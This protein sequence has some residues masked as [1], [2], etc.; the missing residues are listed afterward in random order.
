M[1]YL[2]KMKGHMDMTK[3]PRDLPPIALQVCVVQDVTS[4]RQLVDEIQKYL[5]TIVLMQG[6]LIRDDPY[7]VLDPSV[8][9]TKRKWI[10]MHMIAYINTE[11]QE[12]VGQAPRI[13]Q[14]GKLL[15]DEGEG[16]TK[17]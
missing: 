12:I 11:V 1:D 6:M 8:L 4:K 17:Q 2:V 16:I 3:C 15:L 9:D 10:P 5:N 7:G 13:D 14:D